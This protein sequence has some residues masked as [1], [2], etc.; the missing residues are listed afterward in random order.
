M[1]EPQPK[2]I[3]FEKVLKMQDQQ[4]RESVQRLKKSIETL[5]EMKKR[6]EEWRAIALEQGDERSAALYESEMTDYDI[7]IIE[8]KSLEGEAELAS[9]D[10]WQRH[11]NQVMDVE[12][13]LMQESIL[14]DIKE[15]IE[16]INSE[17]EFLS[18]SIDSMEEGA[19]K[20]KD[21]A[22]IKDLQTERKSLELTLKRHDENTP[23]KDDEDDVD[24]E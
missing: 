14:Q 1:K 22:K 16:N 24:L 6:Y 20:K 15:E 23:D 10:R 9:I 3:P 12:H 4:D 7:L 18:V 5:K 17:L 11:F 13:D 2:I 21:M 8:A 19:D